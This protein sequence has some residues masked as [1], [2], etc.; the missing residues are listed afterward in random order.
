[1][2]PA[3]GT[4]PLLH[5]DAL[6]L[7]YDPAKTALF[8]GLTLEIPKDSAIVLQGPS[9]VGKSTLL[10][11]IAGLEARA[12]GDLHFN[13]KLVAPNDVPSFR[14]QAVYVAQTPPRMPMQVEE[15][16]RAP[17]AFCNQSQQYDRDHVEALC[18]Q[19]MLPT[20]LLEQDLAELSG[21]EAQRFGVLRALVV[22]PTL[23]LLDEPASSLDAEARS[24]MASALKRW[25]S[26]GGRSTVIC[27][28]DPSWCTS[29]QTDTWNLSAGGK[30]AIETHPS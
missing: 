15:S 17:F 18:E 22:K 24:A 9:G 13:G 2:M 30:L 14:R 11:C 8:S 23:L 4:P 7:A 1:M 27:S 26:D 25:F 28:H 19:L 21:G 12:K 3:V 10:R 20:N 16:L 5:L 29:L 6:S